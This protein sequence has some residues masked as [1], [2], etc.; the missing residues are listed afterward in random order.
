MPGYD[1]TGEWAYRYASIPI[2]YLPKFEFLMICSISSFIS[3][4]M[5]F[6]VLGWKARNLLAALWNLSGCKK[7]VKAQK[8]DMGALRRQAAGFEGKIALD[9]EELLDTIQH[10]MLEKARKHR[11]NQATSEPPCS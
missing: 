9:E 4:V 6:C 5:L 7:E 1:N 11:H 8:K 10:D 3:F 2:C